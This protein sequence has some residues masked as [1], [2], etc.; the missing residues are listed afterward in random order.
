MISQVRILREKLKRQKEGNDKFQ[1]EIHRKDV[2][3]QRLRDKVKKYEDMVRN[4]QL[5]E[6]DRL[7]QKLTIL[8]ADL[9]DKEAKIMVS[10][11]QCRVSV[12]FSG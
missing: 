8:E 5:D 10:F 2:E 7:Q 9:T 12:A 4:K 3:I 1:D 6:R 11:I